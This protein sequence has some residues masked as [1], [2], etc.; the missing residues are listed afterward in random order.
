M[1]KSGA[2]RQMRCMFA[3]QVVLLLT[4]CTFTVPVGLVFP[5]DLC[6]PQCPGAAKGLVLN[7]ICSIAGD[8]FKLF[9]SRS[10]VSLKYEIPNDSAVTRKH[11][12]SN[13]HSQQ[14]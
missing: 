13:S 14:Q 5:L 12:L 3:E 11:R 1:A 10:A 4:P 8:R 7:D 9:H 2:P 6:S